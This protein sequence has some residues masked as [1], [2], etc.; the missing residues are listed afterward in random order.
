MK[1][2][3]FF[4]GLLLSTNLTP[5]DFYTDPDGNLVFTEAYHRKRGFCCKSGCRHCPFGFGKV[6]DEDTPTEVSINRDDLKLSD[7]TAD[8]ILWK[9]SEFIED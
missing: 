6:V 3:N 8:E 4:R 5:E 2:L 7:L 9:Y 1:G